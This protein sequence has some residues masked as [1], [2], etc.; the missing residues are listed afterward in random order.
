MPFTLNPNRKIVIKHKEGDDELE[1][2]FVFPCMEEREDLDELLKKLEGFDP[3]EPNP[4]S[5]IKLMWY[6]LRTA[7]QEVKGITNE[8]TGE[9]IV[10]N[11][12]PEM[13]KVV[14]DF[15][16]GLEGMQEKIFTAYVGPKGKNLKSGAT[17]Q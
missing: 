10:I 15:L 11:G 7:L 1:A 13:Q 4:K 3:N 5:G 17:Q 12:D 9:P 8:E 14:F 6:T 2:V 16:I